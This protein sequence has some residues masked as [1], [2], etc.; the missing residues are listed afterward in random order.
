MKFSPPLQG[1]HLSF[2]PEGRHRWLVFGLVVLIQFAALAY[3]GWRWHNISV[4]GIP[5][6][7]RA[8]PRLEIST[9]GTDY[10]RVVFPEDTTQWLDETPPEVGQQI[11][12]AI[13]R[14]ASGLMKVEGASASKPDSGSDYMRA[15]VVSYEDGRVQFQVGFDRYRLSPEMADGIYS[16]RTDDSI[17]ASIR[18]KRGEGVIEGIFVNGVPL[19]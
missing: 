18:I 15:E 6:Q 4:D 3:V 1:I 5:Y 17:I 19:E 13:S 8:V 12:V 7:W 11:Y 9:F 14:D 2:S 16:L 10:V